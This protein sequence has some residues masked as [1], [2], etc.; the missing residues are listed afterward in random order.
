MRPW[1][2]LAV[3][4]FDSWQ[5]R[6]LALNVSVHNH[7]SRNTAVTDILYGTYIVYWQRSQDDLYDHQKAADSHHRI[8][9]FYAFRKKNNLKNIDVLWSPS[10]R[11]V[12]I[13]GYVVLLSVCF[14]WALLC[15]GIY[16]CIMLCWVLILR[17]VINSG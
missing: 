7:F 10:S 3:N 2:S 6:L 14:V 16:I 11:N 9:F 4:A 13:W 17:Y 1:I 5:R 12:V 8:K 15:A